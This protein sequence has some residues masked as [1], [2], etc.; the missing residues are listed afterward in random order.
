LLFTPRNKFQGYKLK[1]AEASYRQPA[2][3]GLSFYPGDLSL[4]VNRNRVI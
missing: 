2:S 1:Q 4:G 3:A